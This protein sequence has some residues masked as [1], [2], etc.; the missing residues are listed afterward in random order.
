MQTA[1]DDS[2]AA[3]RGIGTTINTISEITTALTAAIENQGASTREIAQ[4]VTQ[5]A[6]RASEVATDITE[7]NRNASETGAAS[8]QVL[9]SVKALAGE[10]GGLKDKVDRFLASVRAA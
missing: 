4:N 8:A 10:S 9:I 1:T 3:I 6:E 7:L 2:V 5:V